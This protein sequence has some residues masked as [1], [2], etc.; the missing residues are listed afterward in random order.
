MSIRSRNLGKG[1]LM[2]PW[3]AL[4]VFFCGVACLA[5]EAAHYRLRATGLRATERS[6]SALS[7]L[8]FL[9]S[10]CVVVGAWCA[11]RLW[12]RSCPPERFP[13]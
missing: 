11:R 2:T 4:P 9:L 8:W 13:S 7:P 3:R 12:T 1:R 5:G 6:T 10:A